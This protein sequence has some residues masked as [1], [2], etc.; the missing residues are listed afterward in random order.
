MAGAASWQQVKGGGPWNSAC[1]IRIPIWVSVKKWRSLSGEW[2]VFL[3]GS[4]WGRGPFGCW[5]GGRGRRAVASQVSGRGGRTLPSGRLELLVPLEFARTITDYYGS[6]TAS[7]HTLMGIN[8]NKSAQQGDSTEIESLNSI[9][10]C[11]CKGSCWSQCHW[12]TWNSLYVQ[13]LVKCQS[14]G[15]HSWYKFCSLLSLK[16]MQSYSLRGN[17]L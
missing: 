13:I 5:V 4:G 3:L 8:V 12:F 10:R 7:S 6:R 11:S 17:D 15:T 14:W 9:F 1:K 2:R 16:P